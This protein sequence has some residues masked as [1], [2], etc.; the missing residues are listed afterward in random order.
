[1]VTPNGEAAAKGVAALKG[2]TAAK[3]FTAAKG[4]ICPMS[5]S[6]N[7]GAIL[8]RYFLDVRS[9]L[10]DVAAAWDRIDRGKG[11]EALRDDPRMTML[12]QAA[13]ILTDGHPDRAERMQMGFSLP[14]ELNWRSKWSG[15]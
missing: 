5:A 12:R 7:A 8:D 11:A 2:I 14:Y 9:R 10:L 6:A 1:L 13:A 3:V 4:R 15:V